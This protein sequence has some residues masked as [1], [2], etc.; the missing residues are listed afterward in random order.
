VPLPAHFDVPAPA[1]DIEPEVLG[2]SDLGG[3][4]ALPGADGDEEEAAK[5]RGTLIH[6]LLEH[7]PEVARDERDRAARSILHDCDEAEAESILSE[8]AAVL[9]RPELAELFAPGCLAEVPVTA[10]IGGRRLHGVIDR[11]ITRADSVLAVDFKSNA[12]VPGNAENCPDGLLRQMGAYAL[13]LK[14]IYPERAVE[15]AILWTRT[16]ELMPLPFDI[17]IEALNHAPHLDLGGMRS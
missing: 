1:I 13:Q 16:A 9:E 3:A 4:K 5:R 12:V 6:L 10:Q 17:V 11:L 15:L 8:A 14:Q 2:P 7:L